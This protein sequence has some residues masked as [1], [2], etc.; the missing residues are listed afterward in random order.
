MAFEGSPT[1]EQ[2]V[3]D[4]SA[5][6]V[7]RVQV[8]AAADDASVVAHLAEVARYHQRGPFSMVCELPRLVITNAVQRRL[9][10]QARSD[11]QRRFPGILRAVA[12]VTG[13]EWALLSGIMRAIAWVA[14]PEQPVRIFSDVDH[15][16]QWAHSVFVR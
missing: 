6:P 4:A 16:M 12:I 3:F 15:A 1:S 2:F 11:H 8:P 7:L 5:W 13:Q 14:P 9:F 10:A